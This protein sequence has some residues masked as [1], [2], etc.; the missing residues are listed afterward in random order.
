MPGP[1]GSLP[2]SPRLYLACETET[3]FRR[4]RSLRE[5]NL[6]SHRLKNMELN[7]PSEI[8]EGVTAVCKK[9]FQQTRTDSLS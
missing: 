4:D 9:F 8:G 7:K 1:T 3:A 5:D 2:L 6:L